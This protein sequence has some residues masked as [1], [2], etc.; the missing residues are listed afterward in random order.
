[1]I[2]SYWNIIADF[3]FPSSQSPLLSL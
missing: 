3:T 2:F 1:L